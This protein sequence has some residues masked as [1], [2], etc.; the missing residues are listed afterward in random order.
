MEDD[1]SKQADGLATK[2]FAL[3]AVGVALYGVAVLVVTRS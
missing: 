1:G 3:L 2:L